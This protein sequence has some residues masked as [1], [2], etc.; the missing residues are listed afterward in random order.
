[1]SQ[2]INWIAVFVAGLIGML[3]PAVWY[4]PKVFGNLWREL[5]GISAED[6]KSPAAA[7]AVEAVCS[8]VMSVA[9]AGFMNYF[10][11]QTFLQGLLAGAELW[12]GFVAT[13][14]IVDYRFSNR[15]WKLTLINIGHSLLAM[16]LMGGVLAVWK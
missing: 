10:G 12:L 8:L 4:A 3:V 14:L 13:T 16:G 2:H 5:S 1:V 9:L 6:A 15:P 7:L 11:S